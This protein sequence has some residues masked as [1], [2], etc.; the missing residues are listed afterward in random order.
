MQLLA[1]VYTRKG[2]IHQ[3]EETAVKVTFTIFHNVILQVCNEEMS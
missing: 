1:D 2:D 3:G